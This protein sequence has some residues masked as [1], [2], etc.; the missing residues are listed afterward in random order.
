MKDKRYAVNGRS[1]GLVAIPVGEVPTGIRCLQVNIPDSDDAV[2]MF[3]GM[4]YELTHWTNFAREPSHKGTQWAQA[5]RDAL[6]ASVPFGACGSMAIEFMQEDCILNYREVGSSTWIPIYDGLHCLESNAARQFFDGIMGDYIDQLLQDGTLRGGSDQPGGTYPP[7]PGICKHYHVVLSGNGKWVLPFGL[8]YGDS[9]QVSNLKGAWSD[10]SPAWFCTDGSS[11]G[12]GIC[13][14]GG[15]TH[16]DGDVLNPGAYHM[17]LVMQAG[18]TWYP[19]PITAFVQTSGTTP[20]QVVFQANDGSLSDNT[21]SIEFDV[22]ACAMQEY[23]WCR[24]FD[25]TATDGDFVPPAGTGGVWVDGLGWQASLQ[26]NGYWNVVIAQGWASSNIVRVV[27][28]GTWLTTH[29]AAEVRII[30]GYDTVLTYS[31]L[32]NRPFQFDTHAINITSTGLAFY[33]MTD[34]GLGFADNIITRIT[35]YG[36]GTNPFGTSNC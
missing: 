7:I 4:L 25:F 29:K 14:P 10:G 19:A 27:L 22:E 32:L 15:K 21:G 3:A 17:E 12:L 24:T 11:F 6:L 36:N 5:W 33:I 20:L 2:R 30:N 8:Y 34:S 9:I 31:G 23:A 18:E 16:E 28:E 1:R 13:G 26:S 35:L